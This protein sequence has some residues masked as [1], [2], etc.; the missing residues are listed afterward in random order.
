MVHLGMGLF[1]KVRGHQS[2]YGM[3]GGCEERVLGQLLTRLTPL[4]PPCLQSQWSA[5]AL[6]PRVDALLL[7]GDH[8]LKFNKIVVENSPY[9]T[10]SLSEQME[11][12]RLKDLIVCHFAPA[13]LILLAYFLQIGTSPTCKYI[14]T[15]Y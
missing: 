5:R 7:T 10:P 3:M 1:K 2:L 11:A 14:L 6:P 12:M 9:P 4:S 13:K 8:T 15:F